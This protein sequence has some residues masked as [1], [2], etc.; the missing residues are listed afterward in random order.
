MD[1]TLVRI[2]DILHQY[3]S[4]DV[5]VVDL[6]AAS[7][8]L[9]P[10]FRLPGEAALPIA[11]SPE[12]L[13]SVLVMRELVIG[14]T[15][16]GNLLPR[17]IDAASECSSALFVLFADR[18]DAFVEQGMVGAA[19]DH[20]L[21]IA[22]VHETDHNVFRYAAVLREDDA[23]H[24][25]LRA[26]NE[27]RVSRVL[28]ALRDRAIEELAERLESVEKKAEQT[29]TLRSSLASANRERDSAKAEAAA[30]KKRADAIEKHLKLTHKKM[31]AARKSVSFRIGRATK[32]AWQDGKKKPLRLPSRWLEAFRERSEIPPN[33]PPLRVPAQ[34]SRHQPQADELAVVERENL[35]LDLAPLS[36]PTPGIASVSSRRVGAELDASVRT[37]SLTPKA[38]R[39]QL[40]VERPSFVLV[41]ADGI[42]AGTAW[43]SYGTPDG[44]GV[45]ASLVSLCETCADHQIPIVYWDTRGANRHRLGLPRGVRFDAIYSVSPRTKGMR[46][47]E[48]NPGVEHLAAAVEPSLYSPIGLAPKKPSG[49]VYAGPFDRRLGAPGLS[50]LE[51]LLDAAAATGSLEILDPNH[52]Y[53]GAKASAFAFPERYAD[54]CSNRPQAEHE[55]ARI[56]ELG[57]VLA[58]AP[59]DEIDFVPWDILRA[60]AC[61][62][63]VAT[64]VELTDPDLAR[65]VSIC[66]DSAQASTAIEALT[67]RTRLDLDWQDAF[68]LIL[69]R[70]SLRS[71]LDVISQRVGANRVT[72]PE[73][74]IALLGQINSA[75][76]LDQ[77]RAFLAAQATP[78]SAL[79]LIAGDGLDVARG[80][81]SA[82]GPS[83][84]SVTP[85]SDG[86]REIAVAAEGTTHFLCW[87]ASL[88]K[89]ATA[90][91]DLMSLARMSDEPIV[92]LATRNGNTNDPTYHYGELTE[93]SILAVRRDAASGRIA[94]AA[95][96]PLLTARAMMAEGAKLFAKR[97][98]A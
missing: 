8:G 6:T 12:G 53:V 57:L 70:Y 51:S 85:P 35:L 29:K 20:Q 74:K 86:E 90:V 68:E 48:R 52:A 50:R 42:E 47:D 23:H 15:F 31:V 46:I 92:G 96:N 5:S 36:K 84:L 64:T 26:K 10:Y 73:P 19:T 63:H 67:R 37:R 39:Y 4:A 11:T 61:G 60:L 18:A 59:V 78:L 24:S 81:S 44:R 91:T 80:L 34:V 54:L 77:L 9:S 66:T 69:T 58:G 7:S 21:E 40:E 82:I 28:L 38:Y 13:D 94:A 89:S 88:P 17:L 75:D 16:D 65:S 87:H 1:R 97:R 14:A 56:R 43:G 22:S 32:M 55:A 71:R 83:K 76:E 98:S 93:D 95:A 49:T 33:M 30:Q 72:P 45:A 41:T 62:A 25:T 2:A 27:Y 3:A 79:H